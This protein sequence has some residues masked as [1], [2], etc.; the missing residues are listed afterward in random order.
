VFD[1]SDGRRVTPRYGHPRVF[2]GGWQDRAT[3]YVLARERFEFSYDPEAP[4]RTDGALLS[5]ALP[6]GA[7]SPVRPM[8]GTRSIVFGYGATSTFEAS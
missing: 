1:S 8:T 5:C 6:S 4:D 2:F 3:F 7:C